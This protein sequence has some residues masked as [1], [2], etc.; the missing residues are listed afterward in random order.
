MTKP[1]GKKSGRGFASNHQ[2]SWLWGRH[3]VQET[4][5]AG[6]WP[7]VELLLDEELPP[8]ILREF[9]TLSDAAGVVIQKVT[10]DRIVELCHADDHQGVLARLGEFPS[11]DSV[12]L[13]SD[14]KTVL[15]AFKSDSDNSSLVPLYVIC[16]R[17]QDAHN[18]GAIL[19][20][21]DGMKVTGVVIGER[22]QCAVNPHVVR[23]SAG[24][25]N[26]VNIYRVPDLTAAADGLSALG[27]SLAAATEKS[28]DSIWHKDLRTPAAVIIGSEA[29][30]VATEL[31]NRCQLNLTIPMLGRVTSLNAAVAAGIILYEFRRQQCVRG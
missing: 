9:A 4:L 12:S 22:A 26:H 11:G 20:C 3:A 7:V 23:S 8:E 30:G 29:F 15:Q 31:L 25:V 1:K 14:A 28:T 6:R 13:I 5:I 10:P 21:C 16:D 17:I 24:A 2:R 18:F 19:R 27:L